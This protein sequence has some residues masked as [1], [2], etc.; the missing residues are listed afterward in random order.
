MEDPA[1]TLSADEVA[2]LDL[3]QRRELLALIHVA[4]ARD[5]G[6]EV[7]RMSLQDV[8]AVDAATISRRRRRAL[9]ITTLATVLLI[10]WTFY[11]AIRLPEVHLSRGWDVT[12]V[13]FDILLTIFLGLTAFFA[14][15]QRFLLVV[16]ASGAGALL[17]ADAW[18]DVTTAGRTDRQWS[19]L[20]ALLVEL[21]LAAFL[22][23]ISVM[24]TLRVGR[25][26]LAL[27]RATVEVLP[28]ADSELGTVVDSP[29]PAEED[30]S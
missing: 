7:G 15:R 11:L 5:R 10:P 28:P 18:F 29:L 6:E 14:W 26:V 20:S 25:A 30:V 1:R 8:L 16:S 21:P 3:R 2:A 13:G 4:N 17:I 27:R 12:W 24:F 9:V 22:L 19:T 23:T